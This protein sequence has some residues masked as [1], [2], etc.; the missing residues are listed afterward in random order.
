MA[1]LSDDL[2]LHWLAPWRATAIGSL[3]AATSHGMCLGYFETGPTNG[4]F[5]Q[6]VVGEGPGGSPIADNAAGGGHWIDDDVIA[7]G[8]ARHIGANLNDFTRRFVAERR[9][10]LARRDA[11]D[12]DVER[13]GAADSAGAHL[14]DGVVRAG[15]RAVGVDDLGLA[16]AGDH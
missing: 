16:R 7:H 8:D 4:V 13:V 2:G 9:V 3:R 14:D 1:T 6:E 11:A 10:P 15:L 5:D 12:G